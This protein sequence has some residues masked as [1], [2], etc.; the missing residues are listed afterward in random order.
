MR[1]FTM[2]RQRTVGEREGGLLMFFGARTPDTLPYFGPLQK[3]PESLIESH[4]VYSRAEEKQYVQQRMLE[5][6]DKIADMLEDTKTHVY[7]CGLRDMEAGVDE[8]LQT[9]CSSRGVEW[10]QLR[11]TLRSDGRFHVETY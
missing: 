3:L 1:A 7:V 10:D 6:S 2:R 9:I 8:S 11:D 5:H 4:L